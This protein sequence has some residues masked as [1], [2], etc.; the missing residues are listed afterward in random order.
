MDKPFSL[1][2]EEFKQT[3]TNVINNSGLPASVMEP[4]LQNYLYELNS[5]VK[6]QYYS[7]KT[8]YEQSLKESNEKVDEDKKSDSK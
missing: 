2:Y 6:N 5:I 4:V 3:L 8:R 7:D 1:M